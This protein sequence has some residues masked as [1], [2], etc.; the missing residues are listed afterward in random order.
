M[1][2]RQSCAQVQELCYADLKLLGLR[3][4]VYSGF[5]RARSQGGEFAGQSR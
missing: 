4:R 2:H 1:I 5:D 3:F